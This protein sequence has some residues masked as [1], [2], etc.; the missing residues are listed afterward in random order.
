MYVSYSS[1]ALFGASSVAG[2]IVPRQN[3]NAVSPFSPFGNY[4]VPAMIADF[5]M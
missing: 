4:R 1:L 5:K 3:V 2:L